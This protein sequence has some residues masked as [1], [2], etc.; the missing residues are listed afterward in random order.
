MEAYLQ[1]CTDT[2]ADRAVIDLLDQILYE[3]CFDTLRTREQLG[4]TVSSGMRLTHGV[5]GFAVLVMSGE[6][7]PAHLD[8]RMDAFL[9]AFAQQLASMSSEEFEKHRASLISAKLQRDPTMAHE[10]DRAWDAIATRRYD[11]N[12]RRDEVAHL[13]AIELAQVQQFYERHLRPNSPARRKL[14]IHVVGRA[15]LEEMAAGAAS[16]HQEVGCLDDFKAQSCCLYP[17]RISM[18]PVLDG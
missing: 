14:S 18:L 3:P 16:G 2:V 5:L 10:S 4:Y 1:A 6:H 17:A 8:A 7:G 15:H 13:R 9:E 11:F 12:T